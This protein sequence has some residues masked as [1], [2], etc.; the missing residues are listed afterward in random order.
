M[1]SRSI[2]ILSDHSNQYSF[3]SPGHFLVGEPEVVLMEIPSTRL[4]RCY[5][6]SCNK[7]GRNCRQTT[8]SAF[9]IRKPKVLAILRED[10]ML[11][12]ERK[13]GVVSASYPL[14]DKAYRTVAVKTPSGQLKR[15]LYCVFYSTA[16]IILCILYV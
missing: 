6:S 10:H 14:R 13:L 3:P 2:C 11:P 8:L 4:S 7:S 9:N 15:F 12:L 5:R 16:Q 1:N